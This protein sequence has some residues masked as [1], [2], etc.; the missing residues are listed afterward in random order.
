M[1]EAGGENEEAPLCVSSVSPPKPPVNLGHESDFPEVVISYSSKDIELL[2]VVRDGL[3]A[4]GIRTIDGTQVKHIPCGRFGCLIKCGAC[5]SGAVWRRL[6]KV[7]LLSPREGVRVHSNSV[8][9][10]PLQQRV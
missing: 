9:L 7:L 6:A 4:A 3:N 10:V 1:A 8:T 5:D 2:R